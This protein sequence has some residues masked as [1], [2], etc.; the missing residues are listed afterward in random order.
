M[1][2]FAV[3][4]KLSFSGKEGKDLKKFLSKVEMYCIALKKN[5]SVHCLVVSW[6]AWP[7]K[8]F[9]NCPQL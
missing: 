3:P 7:T 6:R 8:N 1:A 4:D 9:L 5:N 2:A